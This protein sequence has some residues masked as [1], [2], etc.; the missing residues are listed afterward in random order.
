MIRKRYPAL[1]E[2]KGLLPTL[3]YILGAPSGSGGGIPVNVKVGIDPGL[4]DT[5]LMFGGIV[6]AGFVVSSLIRR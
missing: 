4:R 2:E 6:A 3:S 1:S 5:V